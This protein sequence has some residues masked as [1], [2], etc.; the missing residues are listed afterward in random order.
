MY[1]QSD[2]LVAASGRE[3]QAYVCRDTLCQLEAFGV[4]GLG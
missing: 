1:G 2:A 3:G 4:F